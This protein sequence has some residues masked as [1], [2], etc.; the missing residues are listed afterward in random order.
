[1]NTLNILLV[2]NSLTQYYQERINHGT[3]SGYDLYCPEDVIILPNCVGTLDFKVRCSPQFPNGVSGYYLYPRSSI[4]KTPLIM[5]N[6]VGIIDHGYRGNIMAK[7]LNTSNE[8]YQV[9]AGERLFQ[10]CMP[11]LVP[12]I[13][14]FV[15]QLDATERGEGGFG[16]TGK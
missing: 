10:L 11:T 7:V 8:P 15:D 1:M 14:K 6:S 9:K 2:D 4:S 13:V 5:A 12:F 16:S 3:D